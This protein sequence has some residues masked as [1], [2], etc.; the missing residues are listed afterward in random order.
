MIRYIGDLQV[1]AITE[2][3]ELPECYAC[4]DTGYLCGAALFLC[5]IEQ[6][7]YSRP[8]PCRRNT[9]RPDCLV[10]EVVDTRLLEQDCNELHE[11][12][13]EQWQK[14]IA[15]KKDQEQIKKQTAHLAESLSQSVQVPNQILDYP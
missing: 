11:E 14:M 8:V 15:N 2:E 5:G 1:Q 4:E 6:Y 12:I 10:A 13:K 9:C 3:I 7:L